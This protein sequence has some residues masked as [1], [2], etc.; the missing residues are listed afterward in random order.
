MVQ[1]K[2]RHR[3]KNKDIRKILEELNSIFSKSFFDFSS[4]V[5]TGVIEGFD[6]VLVDDSVD[7]MRYENALF[8]TLHGINKYR[9]SERFVVVDMGAVGF[10]VNGADI[11]APGI[12]DA[13]TTICEGD[14]V[15]ICDEKNRKPLAVGLALMG[16]E[17]MITSKSDKAIRNIHY[18]GDV[19]WKAISVK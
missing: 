4:S 13:D 7:F 18:V 1:I 11:M 2:N 3:L 14:F 15:W 17:Q 6:V 8:L 5:E 16:G 12:V 10:V 9:P 19:L